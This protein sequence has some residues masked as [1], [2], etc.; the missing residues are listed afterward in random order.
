MKYFLIFC[1][2]QMRLE[3]DIGSA[4]GMNPRYLA[5]LREDITRMEGDL[6]KH[7]LLQENQ[8]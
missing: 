2:W 8:K 5:K 3:H 6:M 4:T 7:E 1:L